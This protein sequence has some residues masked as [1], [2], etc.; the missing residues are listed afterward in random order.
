MCADGSLIQNQNSPSRQEG[1]TL[2]DLLKEKI[3][4]IV[5]SIRWLL[6][7]LVSK[8]AMDRNVSSGVQN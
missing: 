5:M 6:C 4:G 3:N 8:L 7:V 2:R 1:H